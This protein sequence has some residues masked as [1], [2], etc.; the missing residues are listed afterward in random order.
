MLLN[1]ILMPFH[2]NLLY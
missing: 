1:Y 2:P